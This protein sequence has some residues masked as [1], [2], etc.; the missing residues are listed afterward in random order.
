MFKGVKGENATA[1][2]VF[3][4][5]ISR[6]LYIRPSHQCSI[7]L[8]NMQVW[9]NTSVCNRLPHL[10]KIKLFNLTDIKSFIQC[11][12]KILWIAWYNISQ[13][14]TLKLRRLANLHVFKYT[15]KSLTKWYTSFIYSFSN[16]VTPS[17]FIICVYRLSYQ[18]SKC[19]LWC[20]RY[21]SFSFLRPTCMFIIGVSFSSNLV[22]WF[23]KVKFKYLRVNSFFL[24][25]M[26]LR[27]NIFIKLNRLFNSFT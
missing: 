24:N 22:N 5:F 14:E 7:S 11:K 23:A 8:T 12:H 19:L 18:K 26:N 4:Y 21:S 1:Y 20:C 9:F 16:M 17:I 10:S 2:C 13:K 27:L 15:W 3:C 6:C 25:H